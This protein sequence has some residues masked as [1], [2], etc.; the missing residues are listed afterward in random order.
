M[1]TIAVNTSSDIQFQTVHGIS[2]PD[3][4]FCSYN[5]QRSLTS[6]EV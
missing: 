3:V 5:K 6:N 1:E 4:D 2:M